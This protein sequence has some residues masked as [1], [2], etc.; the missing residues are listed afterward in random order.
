MLYYYVILFT[1]FCFFMIVLMILLSQFYVQDK[2]KAPAVSIEPL[3]MPSDEDIAETPNVT[4]I[5]KKK[6][7]NLI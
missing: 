7:K 1:F 3:A 4:K 5:L 2:G 6:F